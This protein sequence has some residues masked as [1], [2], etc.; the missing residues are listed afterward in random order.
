M[1][2]GKTK[3]SR[4]TTSTP[5][6]TSGSKPTPQ[7]GTSKS[8]PIKGATAKSP[9]A[10]TTASKTQA[11]VK[12]SVKISRE[13][14][15]PTK[16]PGQTPDFNKSFGGGTAKAGAAA[17]KKTD[18]PEAGAER[19][20]LDEGAKAAL[21]ARVIAGQGAGV[22]GGPL[23]TQSSAVRKIGAA[24]GAGAGILAVQQGRAALDSSRGAGERVVSGLQAAGNAAHASDGAT[25]A[26]D[27]LLT[28]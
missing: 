1:D 28:Y 7:K 4:T 13:G 19:S 2:A 12:D 5:K 25:H 14:K 20:A 17:P 26:A 24:G 18:K 22:K 8:A 3:S 9:A 10:K 15:A 16:A 11:P 27:I 23:P 21:Q 6:K